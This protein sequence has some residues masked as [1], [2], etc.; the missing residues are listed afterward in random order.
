MLKLCFNATT[1][2]YMDIYKA[3]KEI[4]DAGYEAVEIALNDTHLHPYLSSDEKIQSVRRYCDELGLVL[5]SVAAGGPTYLTQE[6]YEPSMIC[7]SEKGRRL[8]LDAYKAAIELGEKIGSPLVNVN[9]G[10]L[11]EQSAEKADEYFRK[12]MEELIKECDR[13]TL[14]LEQEPGF[15]VGTT[16]MAIKY[17]QEINS[18]KLKFNLDIGHVFCCEPE[19]E[20]YDNVRK[21][22]PYAAHIHIE[23]IKNRIHFHEIP[24]EGDIDFERIVG[25]IEESVFDGYVCVELH[26]HDQQWERALSQ[27]RDYLLSLMQGKGVA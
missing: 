23:D 9:S 3:L 22:L 24:G 10:I 26:N 17:I 12:G 13:T 21:S 1:L 4:K 6:A 15:Y 14:V 16:D 7:E 20:C 25:M 19:E 5:A 18:P 8:R 2:R 11:K 27:S